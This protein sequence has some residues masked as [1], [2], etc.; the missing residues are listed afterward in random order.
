[1]VRFHHAPLAMTRK[2]KYSYED[3]AE[4]VASS[5]NV[6]EVLRRLGC[7]SSGSMH[8]HI[9]KR[10]REQGID[11]SHF[12]PRKAAANNLPKSKPLL[13]GEILVLDE[14][15]RNRRKSYQLRRSLKKIGVSHKC[16]RCGL[17]GWQ[18]EAL[19]L[20]V[21]H[22]NGNWRDNR[23]ENLR[24]LCPNCHSLTKTWKNKSRRH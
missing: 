24:F 14:S 19:T 9:S 17:T 23:P 6:S 1:M 7:S 11:R 5:F 22:V 21:D 8:S 13:P 20:D 12:D 3:L 15:R 2:Y 18:G 4:A 16:S 10:I